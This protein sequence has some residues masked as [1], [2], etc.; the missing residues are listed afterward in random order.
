MRTLVLLPL[1]VAGLRILGFRRTSGFLL[2]DETSAPGGANLPVAHSL[3]C[4][5]QRAAP[6]SALPANCLPRALVLCRLLRKRGLQAE[7]RLG[8]GKA[9]GEFAAHAWVEHAGTALGETDHSMRGY[10]SFESTSPSTD[11]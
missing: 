2:S 6:W 1:T 5:V 3:A 4:L 9:D 8:V 7:L 10:T 11:R